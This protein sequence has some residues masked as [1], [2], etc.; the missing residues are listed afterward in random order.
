[1][2]LRTVL[3]ELLEA[4]LGVAKGKEILNVDGSTLSSFLHLTGDIESL[5][6]GI[7]AH[8]VSFACGKVRVVQG[9]KP[10]SCLG[11]REGR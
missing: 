2:R 8:E 6:Q 3:F 10:V 9:A 1:M 7:P 4:G 11:V 5:A